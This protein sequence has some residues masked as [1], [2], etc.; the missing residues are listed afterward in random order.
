MDVPVLFC[1]LAGSVLQFEGNWTDQ[2]ETVRDSGL[3][4]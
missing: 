1:S 2:G 4:Q 3:I